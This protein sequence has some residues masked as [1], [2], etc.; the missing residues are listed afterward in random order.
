MTPDRW[1]LITGIFHSVRARDAAER[2]A[3][4]DEACA[5]DTALRA[6]VNAL[7]AADECAGAFGETPVSFAD[8]PRLEPGASIGPYRITGLIGAGGM[9]EVYRA[10]DARLE[11]DVA[12]KILPLATVDDPDSRRRLVREAR[13]VA[14][15][16]HPHICTIHEVG[17]DNGQA[18]IVMEL[19]DGEPLDRVIREGGLP[20]E[21]A[22]RYG[23][24]ISDALG[25]AHQKGIVH[26]DLKASNVM[27][28]SQGH[29]KVLDF[30]VARRIE[31]IVT[32]P[33]ATHARSSL[34]KAG[35]FVGTLAYMSPEQ[36][37]G[38]AAD[39][40]S[41]V[42]ALGIVLYE[43]TMGVRPFRGHTD[44]ELTSAILNDQSPPIPANP[45]LRATIERCL[46]KSPERRY[47]SAAQVNAALAALQQTGASR[48]TLRYRVAPW[49]GLVL[50][51]LL[52]LTVAVGVAVPRVVSWLRIPASS[53]QTTERSVLEPIATSHNAEWNSRV[54]PDRQWVSYISDAEG[55]PRIWLQKVEGGDPKPL[56][57]QLGRI[58]GHVWSPDGR[59]IAYIL[60][61]PGGKFLQIVQALFGGSP[62]LNIRIDHQFALQ[63]IA[64][65]GDHLYVAVPPWL[66]RV[67]LRTQA[68]EDLTARWTHK[69][70]SIDIRP[71]GKRV[72]F[73]A[74]FQGQTDLWIA[75][76]DGSEL[77]RL[78]DDVFSE[79]DVIWSGTD[80][81]VYSSNRGGQVDLWRMS[82]ADH[83]IQQLTTSAAEEVADAV[84]PDGSILTFQ[85]VRETAD[86]WQIA[87][88]SHTEHPLTSDGQRYFWP[89]VGRRSRALAFQRVK[90]AH[91]NEVFTL[92]DTEVF[93]TT[94]DES[95]LHSSPQ[96]VGE[97][98]APLLSNRAEWM[99]F[100]QWATRNQADT[101]LV[102]VDLSTNRIQPVTEHFQ[103]PGFTS[104]PPFDALGPSMV[105]SR[106]RP[107]LYFV[108]QPPSAA[109][110]VRRF[111]AD[112]SAGE[113]DVIF[114]GARGDRM[115][116]L[117]LSL[118]ETRLAYVRWA[119][120]VTEVRVRTLADGSER[121][122]FAEPS[123]ATAI[124]LT[125]WLDGDLGL[126]VLRSRFNADE[127]LR[128]DV[129]RI[130]VDRTTAMLTTLPRAFPKGARFD[131][132]SGTLY[133]TTAEGGIH[134]L[135]AYSLAERRLGPVTRNVFRG[136]TFSGLAVAPEGALICSRQELKQDIW[137][138]R[139]GR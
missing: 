61:Q 32:D 9:G 35:M 56:T 135:S 17:E 131:A 107:D 110:E 112:R 45:D 83:S 28:T 65:I 42:W 105:W 121:S 38:R 67:D 106:N 75:N 2:G 93:V 15:L 128:V 37:R 114:A 126:L 138:Q 127:T 96:R 95:Q 85:E 89:S 134:N 81:V 72:V 59:E 119:N 87:P 18:Y 113:S 80:A 71:D 53:H 136:V 68:V 25:H 22:I 48:R 77:F 3:L 97:G 98:F 30:G 124:Q 76:P 21:D 20:V 50:M 43:M 117:A 109:P 108:A 1:R 102:A 84:S 60:E 115:R 52:A 130:G 122:L 137:M 123:E 7:L 51:G 31:G 41:D 8:S 49:H 120:G 74:A 116:D 6:E 104:R 129:L 103:N 99:A 78:T 24:Q 39:A 4:L 14:A 82:L 111:R 100:L 133:I 36:L 125:G 73:S 58:S 46:E 29:V 19:I 66:L 16:N 27:V 69:P 63:P 54:S 64:W 62:R 92:L 118:D 34:T 79:R 47:Q 101:R 91:D 86:L 132:A 139:R 26:R 33:T 57:T 13:A 23:L 44:F 10:Y 11:R 12:I 94:R 90:P 40:R 55:A 88:R 5:G 70:S